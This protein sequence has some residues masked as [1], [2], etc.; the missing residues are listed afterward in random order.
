[1]V[2]R[3]RP[4]VAIIALLCGVVAALGWLLFGIGGHRA[5]MLELPDAGM[6]ATVMTMEDASGGWTVDDVRAREFAAWSVWD[7]RGYIV[8]E[9]GAATWIKVTLA[10][11]SN[12]ELRGVLADSEYFTDR[13]DFWEALETAPAGWRHHVSGEAI[14]VDEKM[15]GGRIPAFAV[16]LA[17]GAEKTFYL[18]IEDRFTAASRIVWWARV[19]DFLAAQ[20]RRVLAESVCYGLLVAL[21]LYHAILWVRLRHKDIA[22]YVLGAAAL[23]TF[24][25]VLNGGPA[26]LG[27]AMGSPAK[28]TIGTLALGLHSV[29]LVLF[30][31]EFL[32]L[33][34][35]MPWADAWTK[36]LM[37]V[38]AVVALGALATPWMRTSWWLHLAV[39]TSSVVQISLLVVATMA[40]RKG[41][42]HA[43]FFILASGSMLVSALP[44][45]FNWLAK[46]TRHAEAMGVLGGSALEILLLSLAVADR[47]SE[48]QRAKAEAQRQ[49]VE[50]AQRV[51]TV[52]EAYADELETE[53]RERTRE[54]EAAN[55]DKDRIIMV[56][57]HDLRGPLTG[58]TRAA[59][60]ATNTRTPPVLEQ[61]AE[62]A[63]ATGRHLLL[64]IEDLV[65][66]ARLRAG[67]GHVTGCSVNVLVAPAA[68][69]H[70]NAA[71]RG[72]VTLLVNIPEGLRVE[73]DLVLV[74][75]MVRN[76]VDNAVKHARTN[77]EIAARE[78]GGSVCVSVRDDGKGLPMEVAEW[79]ADP[80]EE[81]AVAGT[82]MGLR[83]CREIARALGFRLEVVK[84]DGGGTILAFSL[85][86]AVAVAS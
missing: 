55:A 59:E 15:L 28:E 82:G 7:G 72:G 45:V 16:E 37:G 83:L 67:A 77:V 41:A 70:R 62:D 18:R 74:Q 33:G 11:D 4:R 69:L 2:L 64:M 40:W 84:A 56:L 38:G 60:F 3:S 78:E 53:V 21:L 20:L 52:Q 32:E 35:R 68:V 9:G 42:R 57:G 51:R 71:N 46:D 65:L 54:L 66:W 17:P 47:F 1:M 63:V 34:A 44:A 85:K 24:N 31:R 8:A 12:V 75:T 61:F 81:R 27:W 86:Q 76:L 43:R 19:G 58:L 25:F 10:N 29:F 26:L 73:T 79:L 49:L 36:G 6:R 39:P 30:A 5:G 80:D 23:V 48:A 50:E 22:W 14:G 13:V